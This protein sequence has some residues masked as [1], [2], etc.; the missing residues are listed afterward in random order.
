MKIKH[1]VVWALLS[2]VS[3]AFVAGGQAAQQAGV[4]APAGTGVPAP[5]VSGPA[6]SSVPRLVKFSGTLKDHLGQ[7]LS[8]TVGVTFALYKDPEGGSPLW[9]E[10]QNLTP[11]EQGHYSVLLGATRNDGLPLELFTAAA[12]EAGRW[13]GVQ[14]Q[15]PGEVEQARVLLV[16]VPYALTA[17][18]AETLGGKPASA[19]LTTGPASTGSSSSTKTASQSTVPLVSSTPNVLAK[20]VDT[21]GT[22]GNSSVSDN[23]TT[24]TTGAPLGALSFGFTGNA[25][26]PTDATATILNQ[27]FVGPVFSGLSFK[28][29]TGAPTP[30]D[31]LTV[32]PSQNVSMTGNASALA[33]KFSGNATPPTDATATIFN[34]AFVGPVFSGLS[35]KVRTGVTPG[36]A[37]TVDS[38]RNIILNGPLAVTIPNCSSGTTL[39]GVVKPNFTINPMGCVLNTATS[40]VHDAIGVV[41]AGAGTTGAA[42]IALF[43][44]ANC[45]FDGSVTGGDYVQISSTV[46]GDCHD[47]GAGF[48][49]TGQVLGRV[50]T[51][52]TGPGLFQMFLFPARGGP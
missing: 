8:E 35:F 32:D 52:G 41:V 24:V 4:S 48:P 27:A 44:Q 19:F 51:S 12:P 11:D 1:R 30:A 22:V 34:Q 38:S 16:S 49:T 26:P 2:F 10:T 21:V 7:P 47:A 9:L 28:V 3:L 29:R 23:G 13:L 5:T 50:I 17:A 6:G 36:D 43:G 25:A 20:F 33:Y 37:L 14:V 40:D 39:N 45:N 42:T 18:N 15:R 31:A 46:A